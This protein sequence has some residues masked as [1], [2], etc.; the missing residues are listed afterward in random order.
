VNAA[1]ASNP[2]TLTITVAAAGAVP[3][4][5]SPSIAAGTV[6]TAFT[7]YTILA[8]GLPTGYF[9]S[10]LPFG[11]SVNSLTGAITGIPLTAGVT[12]AT[13]TASNGAGTSGPLTL[14]ITI[15]A[16]SLTPVITSPVTAPGTVGTTFVTYPIIATGLPSSYS[17]TGLPPG[18]VINTLTGQITGTPTTPGTYVVTISATNSSGTGTTTLTITV[19]APGLS[20]IITSSPPVAQGTGTVGSTF[21]TYTIVATGLPSS[22]F[23]TG[24]PPGLAIDPLTGAITG[25]P[26]TAGSYPVTISATNGSGTGSALLTIVISAAVQSEI[27]NFS[28][29]GISGTGS[30]TMIMGFVIEG[31]TK[32]LLVRGVGPALLSQGLSTALAAPTL[33]LE[34]ST[35]MVAENTG[36]QSNGNGPL[37]TAAALQVGAFALQ[38]GSADSALY[39]TVGSGAYTAVLTSPRG[40]TGSALLEVYDTGG[41]P[42]ARLINGSIRGNAT[43]WDGG[44]IAG[45]VIAGTTSKTVLIR[46]VGPTLTSLGVVN[47]LADPMIVVYSGSTQI[48]TNSGWETG[49]STPAQI[50]SA[51]QLNGAYPVLPGSNDA[52]LLITLEPGAYTI[53]A[54]S[55]S[56]G[57]GV[58]LVEVYDTQ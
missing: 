53:E 11:L 25:T 24:L 44:L 39:T 31:G 4:I 17:A 55:V 22:Y 13:L 33:S 30:N 9:A 52:A 8:T 21:V 29:R 15:A 43:G 1:G 36:W 14:T 47:A 10:G 6:G 54:F 56:G 12:V 57:S 46:G 19:A 16:A 37:L 58:M 28:G 5:I 23:A 18:L 38:N 50:I 48:A 7:T 41:D 32:G 40:T 42:G 51:E 45:F 34:S 2:V 3:I 27:I 26:T 20:P 49:S 35:G